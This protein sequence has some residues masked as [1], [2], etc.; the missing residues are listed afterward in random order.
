[1]GMKIGLSIFV[2]LLL[3]DFLTGQFKKPRALSMNELGTNLLSM[4]IAFTIRALPFAAITYLLVRLFPEWKNSLAHA[5][6]ALLFAAVLM[7]DD[8]G[9]YWLHRLAHKIP[10]LWRLHKTH[11]IPTQLNVLMSA[12]D[13]SLYYLLISINVMAPLLVFT[14]AAQAGAI[15]L[16]LKLTI[17]YLQHA[18][19]R[20]EL[21]LRRFAP[22]RPLLDNFES[23]FSLQEFHHVHHCIGRYGNAYSIYGNFLNFLE[24]LLGTSS[25]HQNCAQDAYGLPVGVKVEPLAVQHLATLP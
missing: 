19:F 6:L 8:Y 24:I 1:M 17:T 16:G 11:H 9:N 5:N 4:G 23:F 12:R 2:I 15:I 18:G 3:L 7:L 14:G 13:S 21:W 20:W 22:G 10:W 25:G